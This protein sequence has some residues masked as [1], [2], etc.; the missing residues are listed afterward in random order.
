MWTKPEHFE[1]WLPPTGMNMRFIHADLRPGGS[2]FYEMAG[3]GIKMYGKVEYLKMQKPTEIVYVQGFADKDGNPSRHPFAPNFPEKMQTTV[4]L[5]SENHGHTRV[6]V[7]W[8]PT[9]NVSKEDLATF[10]QMRAGMTQGWTGSFDKLE[11][12]IKETK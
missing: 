5:A 6:T 9:G 10:I 12:F 1:K 3:N 8:E 7:T 4:T 11:E 2:S